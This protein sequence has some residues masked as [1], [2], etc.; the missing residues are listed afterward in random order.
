[1]NVIKDKLE[2]KVREE[3]IQKNKDYI[4]KMQKQNVFDKTRVQS[5][6][7]VIKAEMDA[8]AKK[9]FKPGKAKQNEVAKTYQNLNENLYQRTKGLLESIDLALLHKKSERPTNIS[10]N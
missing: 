6:L 5:E 10:Q 2:K 1:M 3:F 7:D 8:L 4:S 9:K